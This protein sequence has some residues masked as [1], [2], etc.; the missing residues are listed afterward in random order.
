M[1]ESTQLYFMNDVWMERMVGQPENKA[2]HM[3]HTKCSCAGVNSIYKD[4]LGKRLPNATFSE[5]SS[6]Q[7]T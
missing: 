7:C 2:T 5:A 1:G 6:W 4:G 3:S